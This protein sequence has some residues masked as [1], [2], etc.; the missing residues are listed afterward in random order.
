MHIHPPAFREGTPANCLT[1]KTGRLQHDAET[2]DT[3]LRLD[4]A[5]P[6]KH[7]RRLCGFTD[8][9]ADA[10]P[11]AHAAHT[12][13]R[14]AASTLANAHADTLAGVYSD[15]HSCVH[16]AACIRTDAPAHPDQP[17]HLHPATC[18]SCPDA[19]LTSALPLPCC[20]ALLSHRGLHPPPPVHLRRT[21]VQIH[22]RPV[23]WSVRHRCGQLFFPLRQQTGKRCRIQRK[24]SEDCPMNIGLQEVN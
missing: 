3:V 15:T 21:T 23:G 10:L 19:F 16:S 13:P 18:T 4:P 7:T 6:V 8:A 14:T 11:E 22:E 24:E 12:Y 9:H 1:P 20:E 17:E 5:R 2:Q